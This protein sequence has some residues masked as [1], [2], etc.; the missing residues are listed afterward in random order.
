MEVERERE[1]KKK[2]SKEGRLRKV[3][4]KEDTQAGRPGY[5][6]KPRRPCGVSPVGL[7]ISTDFCY[8]HI[9]KLGPTN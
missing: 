8:A 9:W 1:G 4:R 3:K 6:R 7:K 5:Q 2:E